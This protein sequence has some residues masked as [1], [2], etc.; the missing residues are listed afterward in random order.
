MYF[1][2]DGA[3]SAR[4][5]PYS[6]NSGFYYVR[7]NERTRYFFVS[8]LYAGDLILRSSSHQQALIQVMTEH[9]SMFGLRVKVLGRDMIEFPG[10]WHYH[11]RKDFM[12]QVVKGEVDANIFHMSWTTNK[13]NKLKFFQQMGEWYLDKNC[14]GKTKEEIVGNVTSSLSLIQPCCLPEAEITC[15]YKDKPSKI[16]C[17]DS[18][19]IDKHGRN[20]W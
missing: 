11:R 8:L 20:F 19:P 9:A 5:A 1:Q 6:A 3:H 12:K 10:G 17:N 7:S 15:H 2:D 14:I 4:Y 18:P 13:N 16:P